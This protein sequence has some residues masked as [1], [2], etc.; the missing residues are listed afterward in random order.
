ML[1]GTF[2][3]IHLVVNRGH[4]AAPLRNMIC[5]QGPAA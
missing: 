3:K 2:M 5:V 4:T 1:I